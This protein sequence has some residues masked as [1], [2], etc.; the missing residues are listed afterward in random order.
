[1]PGSKRW[2]TLQRVRYI[3][4]PIVFTLCLVPFLWI[5]LT[6]F[7][8][9]RDDLGANPVETLMDYFGTLGLRFVLIALAVTPLRK[10]TGWAW[11][12]LFRRMIGLFAAFY[13]TNH[14]L[15]YLILDQGLV[16]GPVIEDVVKR[17]YITIGFTALLLLLAMAAT[18]TFA[19]RRRMGKRWQQL[20]NSV[21]VVGILGVWHYWWQV[22]SASDILEP[23]IYLLVLCLLLG[24]R[25]YWRLARPRPVSRNANRANPEGA[26]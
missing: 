24:L 4:K 21:Y 5:A 23:S 10:L 6:A 14:F 15:V 20:H 7:G 19:M 16:L 13:V 18:S 26:A 9:T 3:G 22:K 11:L 12:S 1:M 2:S 8:L 17:P 25:L